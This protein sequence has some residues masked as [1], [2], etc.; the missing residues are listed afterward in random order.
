MWFT[1]L[2]IDPDD[3]YNHKKGGL[4]RYGKLADTNSIVL[5]GDYYST[6]TLTTS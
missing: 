2:F 1:P 3:N 6:V 4:T 5:D